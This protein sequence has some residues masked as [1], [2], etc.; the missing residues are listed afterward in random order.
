MF[1]VRDAAGRIKLDMDDSRAPSHFP[2]EGSDSGLLSPHR[3]EE[4]LRRFL[5]AHN[6]GMDRILL[7]MVAF[8]LLIGCFSPTWSR[9]GG[10]R[11]RARSCSSASPVC[12]RAYWWA[13]SPMG[14][15]AS[16]S[17]ERTLSLIHI[18]EPTRLGMISYAVFCLK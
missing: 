3:N 6:P 5:Y 16:P 15:P 11:V 9:C 14:L 18:S 4:L 10:R 2:D 7:G 17:T 8:S 1:Q 12:W 13:A